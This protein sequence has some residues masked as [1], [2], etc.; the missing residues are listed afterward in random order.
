M[1][2]TTPLPHETVRT[3]AQVGLLAGRSRDIDTAE[4][5]FSAI[6]RSYPDRAMAYAGLAMARLAAGRLRD[7]LAVADRGLRLAQLEEHA[8][9]HAFRGLVL[10]ALGRQMESD[11]ALRQAGQQP[12]ALELLAHPPGAEPPL[13][14]LWEARKETR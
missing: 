10:K 1:D 14:A 12:I 7:A 8:D 3:L 11:A 2:V 5:I 6:E 9:L 4:V 13:A